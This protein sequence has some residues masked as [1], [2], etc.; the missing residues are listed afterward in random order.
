V[1]NARHGEGALSV[2]D[3]KKYASR[4]LQFITEKTG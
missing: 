1:V 3:P 4:L 2:T